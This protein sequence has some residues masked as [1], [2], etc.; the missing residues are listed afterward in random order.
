MKKLLFPTDF[1]TNAN[2]AFIYALH[3]AD[4]MNASIITLHAYT[5]PI[6]APVDGFVVPQTLQT[7]Y[8][9]VDINEFENYKEA[10]PSLRAIAKEQ[11]LE[12]IDMKHALV[13]GSTVIGT[14]LN[15]AEEEAVEMI[16]MGTGGATGL[17]EIFIG[18]N[19]A[20]VMGNANCPVLLVPSQAKFD[21][22][23]DKFAVT[24]DFRKEEL[25]GI[26]KA[27]G[28]AKLFNAHTTCLN[29]DL[30]HTNQ[31]HH[32]MEDVRAVFGSDNIDYVVVDGVNLEKTIIEYLESTDIDLLAMVTHKRNF[33]E[34][35][36]QYSVSKKLAYH[37]TTP[38]LSIQAHT[39]SVLT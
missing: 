7:F 37:S 20:E 35:L 31:Y 4:K 16:V 15:V 38:I 1:S 39:L 27:L 24:T 21:G 23:L 19:G 22:K 8:D 2:N 10:L 36:L 25:K 18:T 29:V 3:L 30:F 34:E 11:G 14:I 17:K 6:V 13:L 12:H 28:F 33:I 32:Q 5:T 26:E 9:N